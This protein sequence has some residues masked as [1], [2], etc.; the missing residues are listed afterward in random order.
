MSLVALLCNAR[1][2][3][4]MCLSSPTAAYSYHTPTP[5]LVY[6]YADCGVNIDLLRY[7]FI[8]DVVY[9]YTDS[10]Y[11]PTV[12]Y[13]CTNCGYVHIY[14]VIRTCGLVYFCI[15][16]GLQYVHAILGVHV[17]HYRV[18][19][20]YITTMGYTSNYCDSRDCRL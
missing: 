14:T 3:I 18:F 1:R 11:A 9:L 4:T 16:C 17:H 20:S 10:T 15:D 6:M 12:V 5:T 19:Y 7:M 2:Y 8:L 13:G